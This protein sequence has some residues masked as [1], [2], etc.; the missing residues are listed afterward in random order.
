MCQK[1]AKDNSFD[2][3]NAHMGESSD[4]FIARLADELQRYL[5]KRSEYLPISLS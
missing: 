5:A 2:S 3:N 4:T 1:L